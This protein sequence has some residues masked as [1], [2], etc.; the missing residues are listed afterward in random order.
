MMKHGKLTASMMARAIKYMTQSTERLTG[1]KAAC[2]PNVMT[3][4]FRVVIGFEAPVPLSL[5]IDELG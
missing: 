2:P 4:D 5:L 1:W 3:V